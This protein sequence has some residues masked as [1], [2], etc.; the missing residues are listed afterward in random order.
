MTLQP[1]FAKS[2][3]KFRR[4]DTLSSA[5]V[6]SDRASNERA[7]RLSKMSGYLHIGMHPRQSI[8]RIHFAWLNWSFQTNF[9]FERVL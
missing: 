3:R 6:A 8:K 9:M 7:V 2:D 4:N 1:A 5:V